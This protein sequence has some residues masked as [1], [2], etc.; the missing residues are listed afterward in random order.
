MGELLLL[1]GALALFELDTTY[2][3]QFLISRPVVVGSVLGFA[4][5]N[6]LLG[7]Q[8]GV[9]TEL[10][11][12]DFIPIGGIVPP[13]GALSAGVAVLTAYFF[14]MAPYLT[15]FIG[16]LGGIL[17]SF[18]ERR[19]RHYRGEVLRKAEPGIIESKLSPG[20]LIF[21]SIVFQ[22]LCVFAFLLIM[23]TVGGP[24]FMYLGG[25]MPDKLHIAFRFSYFIVPWVGLSILFISFS[26][27]PKTD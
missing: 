22:Y 23:L 24:L 10:I 2:I 15:F 1:C 9:F 21:E 25:L 5:G 13:S 20:L 12:L 16:I 19:I 6:F 8:L 27:K 14:G 7:L 4:T 18:V 26:T 17:F 11:Y 3:G